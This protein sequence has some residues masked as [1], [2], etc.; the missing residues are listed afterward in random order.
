MTYMVFDGFDH[1]EVLTW[2]HFK[3]LVKFTIYSFISYSILI[4]YRIVMHK[5]KYF[6]ISLPQNNLIHIHPQLALS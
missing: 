4:Q 2:P 5:I 1:R 3:L 6:F